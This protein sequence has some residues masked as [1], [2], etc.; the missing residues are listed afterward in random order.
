M[1]F[2]K[3]IFQAWKIMVFKI[4]ASGKPWKIEILFGRLITADVEARI[5]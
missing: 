3:I 1:M 5:M 4:A 2:Y